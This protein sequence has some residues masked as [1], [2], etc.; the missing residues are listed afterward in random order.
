M[1]S[2]ELESRHYSRALIRDAYIHQRQLLE[3]ALDS[4]EYAMLQA[5]LHDP[6][7]LPR[8]CRKQSCLQ[9]RLDSLGLASGRAPKAEATGLTA[10]SERGA[11]QQGGASEEQWVSTRKLARLLR[12]RNERLGDQALREQAIADG[13][14]RATG[15]PSSPRTHLRWRWPEAKPWFASQGSG[16]RA[17][18]SE[19]SVP[20]IVEL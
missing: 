16:V 1:Q 9:E 17:P 3:E 6:Y 4:V 11:E 13:V 2:Q 8:L 15:S 5:E 14:A 19:C 12:L 20:P 7:D 10:P 18:S